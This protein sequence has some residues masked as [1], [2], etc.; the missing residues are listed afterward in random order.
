MSIAIWTS[1]AQIAN[2]AG[3]TTPLTLYS[4]SGLSSTRANPVVCDSSGQHAMVYIA[5]ASYKTSVTD[6]NDVPLTNW[7]KDNIDPGVAV[8][9]GALP[10]ANGGTGATT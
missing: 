1:F 6:S 5:T 9:S 10:V 7:S 3:T 2:S 8:G 4:D